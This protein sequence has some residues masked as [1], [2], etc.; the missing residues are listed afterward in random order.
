MICPN[1]TGKT[2][3]EKQSLSCFPCCERGK[4]MCYSLGKYCSINLGSVCVDNLMLRYC[5][6][7]LLLLF[8]NK[9]KQSFHILFQLYKLKR[10]LT[11]LTNNEL[12]FS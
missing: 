6:I 9:S 12:F 5:Y 3:T 7:A 4:E 1:L 2:T 11:L 10:D 8:F